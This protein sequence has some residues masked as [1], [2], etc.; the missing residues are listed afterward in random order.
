LEKPFVLVVDDNEPTCTLITA[1][2]QR[3]FAV[4]VATDGSEALEKLRTR[5]YAAILLDLL[6]PNVDGYDVLDFLSNE[7][8][9]T[10]SRVLIVSAALTLSETARVSRYN[11]CAIISK[12]FE[13]EAILNAVRRCTGTMPAPRGNIISTGVI[14]LLAD[15]LQRRLL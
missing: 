14:L 12:P 13:V 3:E 11:V 9:D 7:Q 2:L 10:L 5:Y 8:P 15:L 1:L 6:M 4:D